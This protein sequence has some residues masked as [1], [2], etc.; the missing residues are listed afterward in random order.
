MV[1]AS[2]EG[3]SSTKRLAPTGALA[4]LTVLFLNAFVDIGHKITVQNT[5]FKNYDG[6]EQVFLTAIV[7]SL[8]LWP[9]IL[10]FVPAGTV[11]DAIPKH[12]VMR[13]ASWMAVI[14]TS[15]I[16]FFYYQGWFWPAFAMTLILAIQ[17]AFYSPAKYSFIR[18]LYGEDHIAEGNGKVQATTLFAVLVSTFAF[19]IVFETLFNE[20]ASKNETLLQV[21]PIG[22]LLIGFSLIELFCAYR[23][24]QLESPT[25]QS[26]IQAIASLHKSA[27]MRTALK[28]ILELRI[29]WLSAIGLSLFWAFGQMLLAV[30]PAYAK[31]S[32]AITNTI[33]IQG[34]IACIGLGIAIGSMLAARLSKGRINLSLIPIGIAGMCLGMSLMTFIS[35]P[36]LHAMNCLMIGITGGLFAVPLNALVQRHANPHQLGKV[37]A[38]QNLAQNIAMLSFLIL[39]VLASITAFNSETFLRA[40]AVVGILGFGYNYFILR[41]H[42]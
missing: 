22:F 15:L 7:N 30:F 5:I 14:I 9:F 32:M 28:P 23:I 2:T 8:I 31:E 35:I 29:I 36:W 21:A 13:F 19:S 18:Q 10:L 4:Y 33:I 20:A 38:G 11:S 34:I 12:K 24:P 17:S 1:T 25:D 41:R 42:F 27:N 3:H 16:T 40:I 39:T 6:N 37:I 26:P